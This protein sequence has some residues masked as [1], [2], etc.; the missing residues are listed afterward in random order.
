MRRI[1]FPWL[2][3]GSSAAWIAA[4]SLAVQSELDDKP[5]SAGGAPAADASGMDAD[6]AE[7]RG[8]DAPADVAQDVSSEAV[9]EAGADVADADGS[10]EDAPGETGACG[11]CNAATEC[12]GN[13][14]VDL[15]SDERHCGSCGHACSAGRE[16]N[17]GVCSS[18]WVSMRQ[19]PT[20]SERAR[21]CAV[22]TGNRV[23]IW[24]GVDQANA[25]RNDGLLYDP[26]ADVWEAMS[27]G[28]STPAARAEP[29]CLWTGTRVFVWGGVKP[30]P[31][32]AKDDVFNDGAL[33]D[34]ATDT[35][36]ALPTGGPV[37]R[38][39]P[40]A[41]WTGTSAIVWGGTDPTNNHGV[42]SG[43][44]WSE[45]KGW[46]AVSTTGAPT[47]NKE[48]AGVW[49]GASL[50]IFGGRDDAGG[51]VSN[52]LF[53]YKPAT[54]AWSEVKPAETPAV[55]APAARSSACVALSD[56]RMMIWGGFDKNIN[57]LNNGAR[58]DLTLP[59]SWTSLINTNA[60]VARACVPFE[61]GWVAVDGSR[62][63]VL[64]GVTKEP[65]DVATDGGIYDLANDQWSAIVSW[66]SELHR[67]G[68]GV[69]TGEEFVV[70]GG[71]NGSTLL[72]GGSRWKP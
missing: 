68:I 20:S 41:L 13:E 46:S 69:W 17:E 36:E 44:T 49:D 14:C 42:G 15:T 52:T 51:A 45:N 39:R 25:P 71:Y 23:F 60:P 3:A 6:A 34:P 55:K 16:C 5:K 64:G 35:W 1:V 28:P 58:V 72:L 53:A 33:Y 43:A 31:A 4:C 24:G 61:S 32:P 62:A 48:L 38:A 7:D 10:G 54:D 12:C 30:Q 9:V 19:A 18:G 65:D 50:L 56:S 59:P 2:V 8:L 21:A 47:K 57:P 63:Y 11:T 29:V 40:V 67:G 70:W 27:A 66:G 26:K 22:W 37:G